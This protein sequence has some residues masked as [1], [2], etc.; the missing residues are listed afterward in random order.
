MPSGVHPRRARQSSSSSCSAGQPAIRARTPGRAVAAP[1]PARPASDP[2]QQLLQPRLPPDRI[3]SWAVAGGHRLIVGCSHNTMIDSGRPRPLPG[4]A[5]TSQIT[6]SGWST[7]GHQR[8]EGTTSRQPTRSRSWGNAGCDSD[9][10]PEGLGFVVGQQMGSTDRHS[11]QQDR[12]KSVTD[13]ASARA[14]GAALTCGFLTLVHDSLTLQCT[15]RK[16]GVGSDTEEDGGSTPPAPTVSPP[17]QR[18]CGSAD[19]TGGR[20]RSASTSSGRE[21]T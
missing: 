1:H 9:C 21:S 2:A 3:N 14:L 16:A 15:G 6:N 13:C 20:D 12:W 18:F 11:N 8:L 19:L 7:S 4:P 17:E 10:G 5:L